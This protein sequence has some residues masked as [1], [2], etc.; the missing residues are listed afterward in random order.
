MLTSPA[1]LVVMAVK[2]ECQY[3]ESKSETYE[4]LRLILLETFAH[5]YCPIRLAFVLMVCVFGSDSTCLHKRKQHASFQQILPLG[6]QQMMMAVFLIL[7]YPC[8]DAVG[9]IMILV[10][11][12]LLQYHFI[13]PCSSVISEQQ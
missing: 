11:L 7:L 10:V 3:S 12:K 5:L 4:R 13:Y 2:V 6:Q 1:M 9:I 8:D